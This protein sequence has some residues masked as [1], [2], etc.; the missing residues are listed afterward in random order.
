MLKHVELAFNKLVD[1]K[2]AE[3]R[4]ECNK[5]VP[6]T[7]DIK[8]R[9]YFCDSSYKTLDFRYPTIQDREKTVLFNKIS[10]LFQTFVHETRSTRKKRLYSLIVRGNIANFIVSLTLDAV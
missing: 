10:G 9:N 4:A 5:E 1:R 6:V 3:L 8:L 2:E 7:G